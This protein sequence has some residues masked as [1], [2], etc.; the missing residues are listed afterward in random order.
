MGEKR[1]GVEFVPFVDHLAVADAHDVDRGDLEGDLLGDL[2]GDFFDVVDDFVFDCRLPFLC[3]F[4]F[5]DLLKREKTKNKK[6]C[7]FSSLF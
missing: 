7:V 2:L 6:K 1:Q 3:F 5:S 4:L